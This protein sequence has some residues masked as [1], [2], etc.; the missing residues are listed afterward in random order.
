MTRAFVV[1]ISVSDS[2]DLDSLSKEIEAA[3][4]ESFDVIQVN[5][6]DSTSSSPSA[7]TLTFPIL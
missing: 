3:L 2:S 4:Q 1:Q 6:W 7:P 5:P